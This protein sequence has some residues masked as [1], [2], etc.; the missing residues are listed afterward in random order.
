MG[1]NST[2][3]MSGVETDKLDLGENISPTT[4]TTPTTSKFEPFPGTALSPSI[5][6]RMM[7]DQSSGL[8]SP[9]SEADYAVRADLIREHSVTPSTSTDKGGDH[10]SSADEGTATSQRRRRDT[11]LDHIEPP[12]NQDGKII[13]DYPQQDAQ[14]VVLTFERKCDWAYVPPLSNLPPPRDFPTDAVL[15]RKHM[16]KHD[17]PYKCEDPACRKLRGFTYSG[18]LLR[19][20]REVHKAGAGAARNAFHC[21]FPYCKRNVGSGFT[22]KENLNEHIRRVHRTPATE[23]SSED[24][25]SEL[26]VAAAATDSVVDGASALPPLAVYLPAAQARPDGARQQLDAD[27]LETVRKRKRSVQE[28]TDDFINTHTDTTTKPPNDIVDVKV[29]VREELAS[30]RRS[31]EDSN[32]Q[33]AQLHTLLQERDTRIVKLEEDFRRL[34]EEQRRGGGLGLEQQRVA[35]E[36]VAVAP[37][38][39]E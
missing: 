23:H 38:D 10:N 30:L 39:G 37:G 18:G 28:T 3:D 31:N 24:V 34:E 14:C 4:T 6:S 8:P 2:P 12:R 7:V 16:D 33:I 1:Q 5:S 13:C 26:V 32:R 11:T 15:S 22:R 27:K 21:P 20:R 19:H 17:R 29:D 35:R 9:R 25:V 36:V